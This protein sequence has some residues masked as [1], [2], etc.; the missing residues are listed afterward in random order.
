MTKFVS[1][2]RQTGEPVQA[3][4]VTLTPQSQVF[5]VRLPFGG[6]VW[7]RPTAVTIQSPRQNETLPI[8]DP[9]RVALW[10]LLGVTVFINLFVF[11]NNLAARRRSGGAK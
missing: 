10:S 11:I 4:D 3:G 7:H 9:T 1:W 6:F 2:E 8:A 5:S